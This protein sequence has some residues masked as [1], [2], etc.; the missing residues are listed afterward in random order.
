VGLWKGTLEVMGLNP[1][2]WQGKKVFLTGHTGFKGSW[3]SLLLQTL[4]ASVTG[5]S[6]AD[7]SQPNL[8]DLL[9][10]ATVQSYL[11]DIR[12]QAELE[13][14]L[15]AAAPEIVIHMAAQAL[16]RPAY[17]DPVQTFASNVM[18]TVHLLESLRKLP[19]ACVVLIVTSDKAYLNTEQSQAFTESDP[20]GGRDPY[21]ASKA[22][23]EWVS[24]AY[25]QSFFHS[26]D[27]SAPQKSI[28]RVRAG[29]VIGGGD[30]AQDRLI[31]DIVQAH[32]SGQP[33]ALRNPWAMRPWQHVLEPLAG[34]LML[35]EKLADNPQYAGAWNFGPNEASH[36]RSVAWLAEYLATRFETGP[37]WQQMPGSHPYEARTLNLNSSKAISELKWTPRLSLEQSLDWVAQWYLAHQSGQNMHDY[38][39]HQIQTYLSNSK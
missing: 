24:E 8:F 5:F 26:H 38:T 20:L 37:A 9:D 39:L 2:F 18:G 4:G 29:N 36:P 21:S 30:W 22:C 1:R 27:L 6:L 17:A 10:L 16:V 7:R 33:V 11:G 19:Q 23:A 31:P 34:Y 28:A 14:T 32:L 15:L 13:Q 3:L 35:C 12:Q 25:Q